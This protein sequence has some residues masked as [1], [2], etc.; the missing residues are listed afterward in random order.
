MMKPPN[1][2]ASIVLDAPV[3]D[4]KLLES[5][6]LL[7]WESP[8]N[9]ETIDPIQSVLTPAPCVSGQCEPGDALKFIVVGMTHLTLSTGGILC[10]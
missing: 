9:W 8:R 7:S 5:H 10:T 2:F 3:V 6:S 1:A 4:P